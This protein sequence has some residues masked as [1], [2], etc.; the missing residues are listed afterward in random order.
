MYETESPQWYVVHAKPR[1]EEFAKYYLKLKGVEVLLRT[2]QLESRSDGSDKRWS[3][4][5]ACRNCSETTGCQRT[6]QET[7]EPIEAPD[8]YRDP[9]TVC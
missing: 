7:F 5:R 4:R 6:G 2:L 3:I 9:Y 8:Q 1:K